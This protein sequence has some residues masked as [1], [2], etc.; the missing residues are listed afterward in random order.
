MGEMDIIKIPR[1]SS[2]GIFSDFQRD[3]LRRFDAEFG[4]SA[5][6]YFR[7]AE[8]QEPIFF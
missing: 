2:P 8:S 5:F 4:L 3:F 1:L 6:V 7:Q